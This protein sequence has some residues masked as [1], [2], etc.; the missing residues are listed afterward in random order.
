MSHRGRNRAGDGGSCHLEV[1]LKMSR[2][3]RTRQD[4]RRAAVDYQLESNKK[5]IHLKDELKS[6]N[7]SFKVVL[8]IA[9]R[10]GESWDYI[11]SIGPNLAI[12]LPASHSFD[13]LS[14]LAHFPLQQEA[15][16]LIFVE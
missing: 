12:A 8:V 15:T 2:D 1:H 11:I 6:G 13:F 10:T 16:K 14:A 5:I 7:C 4:R 3:R 9:F